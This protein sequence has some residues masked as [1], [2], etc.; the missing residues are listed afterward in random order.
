MPQA[1][2]EGVSNMVSS[3]MTQAF[4]DLNVS[5]DISA[6]SSEVTSQM[7][8][9]V[10][11]A[12]QQGDDA[13]AAV[14]KASAGIGKLIAQVANLGSNAGIWATIIG[15]VIQLLEEFGEHGLGRFVGTLLENVGKAISG[16]IGNLFTDLIPQIVNGVGD[17]IKGIFEGIMDM[18]SNGAFSKDGGFATVFGSNA[19]YIAEQME[20]LNKRNELLTKSIDALREELNGTLGARALSSYRRAVDMQTEKERNLLEKVRLQMAYSGSHHSFNYNWS[21]FSA[22]EI[23]TFSNAIGRTWS[24]ELTDLS[25][26]EARTLQSYVDMWDKIGDRKSVV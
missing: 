9:Q 26:N 25:P 20:R 18:L 19:H 23:A 3:V 13:Q 2:A 7:Q 21:G 12:M 17:I 15:T 14:Q 11:T 4:S 16:I 10:Q 1:T 8:E 6:L 5:E 22:Q 24:G